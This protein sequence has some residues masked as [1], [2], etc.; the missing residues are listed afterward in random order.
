[1]ELHFCTNA[2]AACGKGIL[3]TAKEPMR[4]K[5]MDEHMMPCAMVNKGSLMCVPIQE[6]IPKA[7]NIIEK[8]FKADAVPAISGNGATQ[9]L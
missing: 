6:P 1:M 8:P 9:P 5:Q 2:G 7:T 4:H 3:R